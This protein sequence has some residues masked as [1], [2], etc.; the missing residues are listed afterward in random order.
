DGK[1]FIAMMKKL[2]YREGIGD[3]LADG[4]VEAAEK[5]GG[6]AKY[7]LSHMKG[8]PSVEPFRTCKGWGL[9]VA[10]SPV[11]GRHLRGATMGSARFGP[12]PRP[13]STP[14]DPAGYENQ[15]EITFWQA[16]SKE[17]EDNLGICSYVG[18]WTGANFLRIGDFVDFIRFGLGMDVDEDDLMEHYARVGRNLE[19]AFNALHTDM[20]RED[21]LPPERFRREGIASGPHRGEKADEDK[22]NMMLDEFYELW[23]WEKT[24]M[25]TRRCLE[26]LGLDDV[27]ERLEKAGK[28]AD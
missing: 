2:A 20:G 21:D 10:T 8:Q 4:M 11:A 17:I 24:G 6:D 1:A 12:R 14:V 15:P 5:F 27:I 22:Y 7:Y 9:A 13:G 26:E 28:L 19:K 3:L 23:G 18:T 16:R 25:Q